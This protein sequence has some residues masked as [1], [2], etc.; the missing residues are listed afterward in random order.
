MRKAVDS[1]DCTF[2]KDNN[3]DRWRRCFSFSFRCAT[4][5]AADICDTLVYEN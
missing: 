5:F 1:V 4:G 2:R 3:Q